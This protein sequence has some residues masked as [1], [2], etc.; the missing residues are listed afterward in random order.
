MNKKRKTIGL[1]SIAAGLLIGVNS[2][3]VSATNNIN[4]VQNTKTNWDVTSNDIIT[5]VKYQVRKQL[6]VSSDAKFCPIEN[7][8]IDRREQGTVVCGYVDTEEGRKIFRAI[9]SLDGKYV[10]D[11]IFN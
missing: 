4:T 3:N 5:L 9:T 1:C 6:G 2:I 11:I 10:L 7:F 8:I